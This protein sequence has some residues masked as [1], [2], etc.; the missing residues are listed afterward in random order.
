M[1]WVEARPHT[2]V[3]VS[4][5]RLQS[6]YFL[7]CI[8]LQVFGFDENLS[9]SKWIALINSPLS[10]S[11]FF[12]FNISSCAFL[13][14]NKNFYRL[15]SRHLAK[16]TKCFTLF[17]THFHEITDLANTVD[18][19]KNSHMVAVSDKDTF[20]L[21]YQVRAGVMDKS[22]GIHVAKLAH[23]PKEVV[24]MA[25]KTYDE[26]ED[27]YGQL[28]SSKDGKQ[29]AQIFVDAIERLTQFDP[30]TVGDDQLTKAVEAIRANVKNSGNAYL[31]EAFPQ[32]FI[33]SLNTMWRL[34]PFKKSEN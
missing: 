13:T 22:F 19:V 5:G 9:W 1:N 18:T 33:W 10:V 26:S 8:Q 12:F 14:P 6:K 15:P 11:F 4:L 29:S 2:K 30:D 24:E 7:L 31:K 32:L 23:F 21:L 28:Q 17:A 20:T 16:E 34:T 3:V 27:H 25:Q